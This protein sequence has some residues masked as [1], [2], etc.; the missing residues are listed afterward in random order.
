MSRLENLSCCGME[1]FVG[2]NERNKSPATLFADF[3]DA[4]AAGD[5]WGDG[6]YQPA[7]VIMNEVTRERNPSDMEMYRLAIGQGE[8]F[9]NWIRENKLGTVH[10]TASR[11]NVNSGNQLRAI[12][13]TP[14]WRNIKKRPEWKVEEREERDYDDDWY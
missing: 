12:L 14:N 3:C 4:C 13:W 6:H 2:V 11:V 9:A 1:E 8:P 10:I 5:E 7:H